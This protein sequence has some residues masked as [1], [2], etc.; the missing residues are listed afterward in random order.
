MT[1]DTTCVSYLR[2]RASAP[3]PPEP[4]DERRGVQT[5]KE[6]HRPAAQ[7]HPSDLTRTSP[8]TMD[9]G[10]H[11]TFDPGMDDEIDDTG[12]FADAA[13]E[14][15]SFPPT[16]TTVHP[17]STQQAGPHPG[18]VSAWFRIVHRHGAMLVQRPGKY[19]SIDPSHG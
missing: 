2:R 9:F 3:R 6:A 13:D 1:S 10:R 15:F 12:L 16:Q 7:D 18:S 5:V 17:S 11:L 14:D 4:V 19:L 8:L